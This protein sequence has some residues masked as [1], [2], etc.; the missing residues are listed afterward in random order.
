VKRSYRLAVYCGAAPLATGTSLFLLWLA[1]RWDR[2]FFA[3]TAVIYGGLALFVVGVGALVRYA[4]LGLRQ[5]PPHLPRRQIGINVA[6]ALSLLLLNF[7][8]AWGIVTVGV[9]LE[10]RYV[11]TIRNDTARPLTRVRIFGGGASFRLPLL[12][13]H[14]TVAQAVWFSQDGELRFEA[15][16]NQQH[17]SQ[18]VESYVTG[19]HGGRADVVVQSDAAVAVTL[20]D[21][22]GKII[23]AS[24]PDAPRGDKPADR[25]VLK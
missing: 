11:L 4:W 18:T 3:G 22:T 8:A 17:L 10:T 20:R 12:E 7:P 23:P 2:L 1:T 19:G 13:P 21:K 15:D 9:A 16:S 14:E 5:P 25:P 24:T 6:S